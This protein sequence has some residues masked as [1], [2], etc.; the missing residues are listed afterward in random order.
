MARGSKRSQRGTSA[1]AN[2]VAVSPSRLS[3]LNFLTEIEDRRTWH[4]L[5]SERNA[6]SF[7][8]AT[9][10]LVIPPANV[11]KNKNQ[12]KFKGPK[13]TLPHT[14]GFEAPQQVLVCVRRKTRKEVLFAKNKTG[15]GARKFKRRRSWLSEISCRG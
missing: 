13:L 7:K 4:P 12:S 5:G 1:T 8:R 6:R 14:I 2:S 15:K 9:H 10:S 11:N 3:G